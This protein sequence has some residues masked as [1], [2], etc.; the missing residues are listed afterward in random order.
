[1]TDQNDEYEEYEL[2]DEVPQVSTQT[3]LVKTGRNS[4]KALKARLENLKKGREKRQKKKELVEY[5]GLKEV[6]R[7]KGPR[8]IYSES[9][10]EESEYSDSE[11]EVPMRGKKKDKRYVKSEKKP[12]KAEIK[13]QKRMAKVEEFMYDL[14]IAKKT[15]KGKSRGNKT[16]VVPVYPQ[17]TPAQ[18]PQERMSEKAKKEI[19]AMF[20]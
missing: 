13:L 19:F 1:M 14:A 16:V 9:E 10:S 15:T 8:M 7:K 3:K 17:Q 2:E 12:T 6:A 11:D 5:F 4:E 20:S 18:A